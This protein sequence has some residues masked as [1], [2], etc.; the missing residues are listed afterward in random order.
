M[1]GYAQRWQFQERLALSARGLAEL[2]RERAQFTEDV[3]G[4]RL[5]SAA[6]DPLLVPALS[7]LFVPAGAMGGRSIQSLREHSLR[8]DQPEGVGGALAVQDCLEGMLGPRTFAPQAL[9]IDADAEA[10]S[11]VL[12]GVLDSGLDRHHPDFAGDRV[13]ARAA[14]VGDGSTD[15]G[16]AD[17]HGTAA[18]GIVAGP[19]RPFA[20]GCRYGIACEA[21]L[22]VAK[23]M[24]NS[25]RSDSFAVEIGAAW[26]IAA[27]A[28]ILSI[29]LGFPRAR[30]A[31]PSIL[32]RSLGRLSRRLRVLIV[33]A[34]GNG[35]PLTDGIKQPA[36]GRSVLAIGATDLHGNVRHDSLRGD[37]KARLFC[38]A[39]GANVVSARVE[40]D[41]AHPVGARDFFNGTSAAAPVVAGFAALLKQHSPGCCADLIAAELARRCTPLD[42]GDAGD[43][44]AGALHA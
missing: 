18:A 20:G 40:A 25:G 30:D 36:A 23:V 5:G 16:T 29:S 9:G 11:G 35:D 43:F 28:Q 31:G 2:L 8:V 21:R 13:A 41:P 34:A 19:R 26:A 42:R 44:G 32:A 1:T 22:I 39:P 27:G 14:F 15:D 37:A 3:V 4:Y 38:V 33:A 7:A 10:G 12:V 6:T 17:S 24:E